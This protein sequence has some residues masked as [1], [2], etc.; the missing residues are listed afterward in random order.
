MDKCT[1][2][3]RMYRPKLRKSRDVEFISNLGPFSELEN[4]CGLHIY[5]LTF[6]FGEIGKS[7]SNIFSDYKNIYDN[8][9]EIFDNL[10]NFI[11]ILI[12][13]EQFWK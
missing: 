11:L 1:R 6:F 12:I 2:R 9:D 3:A 13:A 5:I 4:I 8:S 7:F 10:Y